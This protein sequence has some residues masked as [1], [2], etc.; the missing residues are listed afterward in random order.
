[1][2]EASTNCLSSLGGAFTDHRKI[3][4]TSPDHETIANLSSHLALVF[5][6]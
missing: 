4:L 6:Y 3:I 5:L 1:M 2:I